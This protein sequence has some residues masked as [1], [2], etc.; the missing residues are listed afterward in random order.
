MNCEQL[1][2]TVERII[3]HNQENGFLIFTIKAEP[4]NTVITI[5][6]HAPT[7]RQGELLTVSG[8]WTVHPKF[9]RQFSMQQCMIHPP[10]STAGLKKYLASGMIKGIGPTY[11]ERLVD[12]FGSNVLEIIDQDPQQLKRIAGIG[13]QRLESIVNGWQEHKGISHIMVFLQDKG[14][15]PAY[16]TKIYKKYGHSAIDIVSTTPYRLA[17]EI[18]GIGFKTADQIAQSIGFELHHP[19]RISAGILFVLQ[20]TTS[21]GHLYMKIDATVQKTIA[22]L[23][24]EPEHQTV[25][26]QTVN[27]LIDN[28]KIA[29]IEH[30]ETVLIGLKKHYTCEQSLATRINNL[31]TQPSCTGLNFD[32]IHIQ[33]AQDTD[34]KITLHE[35]QINALLT[36]LQHKVSIIT[37]GPGTGKTTILKTFITILKEHHLTFHLAAPTGR[38]AKRMAQ[39]TGVQALTLHRLLEFDISIMGF[40]RTE[41]NPLDASFIIVD[42]ASMIDVFLAHSLI[43]AVPTNAHLVLIGDID[44]LPS[45]GPG[46]FFHDLI[47]SNI[48]PVS[49]LTHIFR[50]EEN[51]LIVTNAHKINNGEF[52]AS[53]PASDF[54]FI[55][56]QDPEQITRHLNLIYT[57]LLPAHGIRSSDSIVLTPMHRGTAG[58]HT[59]NQ[60][61]QKM[62]N[63]QQKTPHIMHAGIKY[64][65]GDRIMQLR[66][67][68]E[69]R[70]FNG[71]MGIVET[72]D[73]EEKKLQVSFGDKQ[74]SYE[75]GEFDEITLA[76]AVSIHKSQGSEYNAAIIILFMQH[77]TLL[78]RNLIYTAVTR[79]KKLCVII[80]QSKAMAIGLSNTSGRERVTMLCHFLQQTTEL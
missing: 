64:Q 62:L 45:V 12:T 21:I 78:A 3:F 25:I 76:Y 75:S 7:L 20:S 61:L 4:S 6:G 36:S 79:A 51:S 1:Q 34:N 10:T 42:E 68:Y 9:G 65:I 55:K 56:E 2:G 50:Q 66:N 57:K 17:H 77:Y 80:G 22:L 47:A 39:S 67:N 44:Q 49:R 58:T 15:S 27:S 60:N 73:V 71:D 26:E 28:G 70:V 5:Q 18:W 48:I 8:Q 31:L 23:T 63:Y 13:P 72:I 38:A 19:E 53:D 40:E 24:L 11:A 46:N 41:Q 69:K 14:I 74:I 32:K 30:N 35:G 52:P 16:A 29:R 37:G 54:W 43:R 59:L 33:L